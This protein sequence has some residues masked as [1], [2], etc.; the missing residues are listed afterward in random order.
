MNDPDKSL[1]D[2]ELSNLY[3]RSRTDEPPM[4][5]DSAILAQARQAVEKPAHKPLWRHIGW[6][7]PLATV[8][9]AMLTVSLFIQMKQEQPE[10]LA[11]ASREMFDVSPMEEDTFMDEDV[12][13]PKMERERRASSVQKKDRESMGE[14]VPEAM[15][16]PALLPAPS[17]TH[18]PASRQMFKQQ[19]GSAA[20]P[21][22]S[23]AP[24]A[25]SADSL[26]SGAAGG[27]LE[28]FEKQQAETGSELPSG[29]Q[30]DNWLQRIRQLIDQ[31]KPDEAR[32]SL[33]AFRSAYPAHPIPEEIISAIEPA[34]V[35]P[36]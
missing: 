20:S 13:E 3:Q 10:V 16:A 1:H 9:I 2:A 19:S 14:I 17:P 33:N 8:A 25:A 34:G 5:L 7:M 18:S 36:D 23:S 12:P 21:A 27:K 28:N 22:S 29:E 24:A 11:P 31:G 30:I 35:K 15:Q 6:M 4:A 32:E 26:E